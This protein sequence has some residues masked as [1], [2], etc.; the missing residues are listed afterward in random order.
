MNNGEYQK[1]IEDFTSTLRISSRFAAAYYNRGNSYEELR[2]NDKALADYDKAIKTFPEFVEA[3]L[4]RGL[5]YARAGDISRA[6]NDFNEAIRLS[7][8]PPEASFGWAE[9]FVA[10]GE[11]DQAIAEYSKA[12]RLKPKNA[13]A[14]Y[15]R[16]LVYAKRGEHKKAI[17]DYD[18][19]IRQE[20]NDVFFH[21][22]LA[23]LYATCPSETIRDASKALLHAKKVCE[24]T[25]WQ[26][27][28]CFDTLAAAYAASGDFKEAVN[29]QEK[30]MLATATMPVAEQKNFRERLLLYK[31]GKPYLEIK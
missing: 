2:E 21:D 1:A 5:F 30:A 3:F 25:R 31:Q 22:S 29:W 14:Y 28:I 11:P 18:E 17:A 26:K 24:L 9:I 13:V 16:G 27:P 4:S 10:K 6:I 7:P 23:W 19:A 20:P 8:A 12:I 15:R